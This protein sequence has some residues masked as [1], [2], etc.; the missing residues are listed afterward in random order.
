MGIVGK[1]NRSVLGKEM[2]RACFALAIVK[3]DGPLP[4]SFLIVV[5]FTEMS[6]DALARTGVGA[7]T[8][9]KGVVGELL[10]RNRA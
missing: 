3:D 9:D 4:T 10:A 1:R 2:E 8:F 7:E 6:D 5:E